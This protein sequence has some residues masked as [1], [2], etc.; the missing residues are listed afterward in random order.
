M[1]R[2]HR[3][4]TSARTGLLTVTGHADRVSLCLTFDRYGE[5]GDELEVLRQLARLLLPYDLDPRPLHF[6]SPDAGE[7]AVI[8]V[9][10]TGQ[11][12]AVVA[13]EPRQ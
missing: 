4:V 3:I 12:F 1:T 5:L 8:D 10:T 6:E 11:A 9:D 2:T 7:R 13:R